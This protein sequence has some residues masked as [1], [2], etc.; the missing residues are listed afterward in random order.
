MQFNPDN[1]VRCDDRLCENVCEVVCQGF[2]WDPLYL[3]ASK[4]TKRAE[5][6][7]VTL[8]TLNGYKVYSDTIWLCKLANSFIKFIY[9]FNLSIC[10]RLIKSAQSLVRQTVSANNDCGSWFTLACHSDWSQYCWSQRSGPS[11][12]YR[13]NLIL[14]CLTSLINSFLHHLYGHLVAVLHEP[15]IIK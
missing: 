3:T 1:D 5:S 11:F 8:V 14:Q 15:V 10:L 9:F 4:F 12:L 13:H 6:I 7:D 2:R